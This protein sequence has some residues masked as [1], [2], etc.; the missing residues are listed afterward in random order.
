M[1]LAG[2]AVASLCL[3]AVPAIAQVQD[4]IVEP[5]D[6]D[7]TWRLESAWAALRGVSPEPRFKFLFRRDVDKGYLPTLGPTPLRFGNADLFDRNNLISLDTILAPRMEGMAESIEPA[8]EE[9]VEPAEGTELAQA[10]EASEPMTEQTQFPAPP[11]VVA[12]PSALGPTSSETA[13]V[14]NTALH[15]QEAIPAL[16]PRLVLKFFEPTPAVRQDTMGVAVPFV[17][18]FQSTPP[19]IMESEATYQQVESPQQ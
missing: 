3:F 16:D 6:K 9:F 7:W 5:E 1:R 19:L 11:E 17:M 8:D 10:D 15:R 14:V 4:E 12:T 18:P 13:S 2:P